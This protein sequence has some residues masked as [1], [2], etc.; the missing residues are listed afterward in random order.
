MSLPDLPP[1]RKRGSLGLVLPFALALLFIVAW[2]VAWLWMRGEARAQMDDGVI[3]LKR[4]GYEVSWKDRAIAGYPFRLNVTLTDARVRE[5]SGWALETPRLE[6]QAYLHDPT[7][8]LVAAPD[9]AT[10]VRPGGGPVKVG[11]KLIRASI[12]H[13]SNTPPSFSFQGRGLTFEPG[14][15]ARPFS[16]SAADEVEFH[17]RQAPAAVGDEGGVWLSVK[18]GKAQ[19]AGLLGRIAGDGPI[20]ITW[21]S[22]L[23]KMSAFRG[24]DWPGAVRAWTAA[25]GR[26]TVRQ[27]GLTAGRALI[28]AKSGTLT[29]GQDGRV[30]GVLDVTLREAPR[31][32]D[33]MGQTGV[34]APERAQ[35]A[36]A[37]AAAREGT[38]DIATATI[39]FENGQTTLGPVAIA[40]A[41][42]VYQAR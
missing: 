28:G 38:G 31:A 24:E 39:N 4:A 34:I 13:L 29:V 21:D 8:W 7:H 23:S 32:L 20:S 9:G 10:F 17:L 12:S 37:V 2:S 18:N 33:V 3:A 1:P 11:G 40:A 14:A 41:P 5:P 27:A 25:G 35:A 30:R 36:A 6:A 22:T 26:M 15:G 42:K 16:L 19:L